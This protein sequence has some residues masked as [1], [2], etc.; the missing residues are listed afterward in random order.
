LFF[1]ILIGSFG[2]YFLLPIVAAV[3]CA[4]GRDFHYPIMGRRLARYLEDESSQTHAEAGELSADHEDRWVSAMGHFSVI[5][6]LWGMLIPFTA[7][8]LQGK[9]SIFL[10]FQSA[11]TLVFQAFVTL[12]FMGAGFLYLIGFIPL[13]FMAETTKQNSFTNVGMSSLIILAIFMLLVFAII[14]IIPFFHALGQWAGYRVLKG[15]DYRYP[16]IGKLV[17]KYGVSQLAGVEREQAP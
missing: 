12:L 6:A 15:D 13:A 3:F 16:I 17:E 11:Q 10:K 1:V 14:L 4:L 7:W 2:I 9:R 5:I 8:I